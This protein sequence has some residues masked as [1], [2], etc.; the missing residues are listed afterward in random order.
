M[1]ASEIEREAKQAIK[2]RKAAANKALQTKKQNAIIEKKR[3]KSADVII[4]KIAASVNDY[5]L[6]SDPN[7]PLF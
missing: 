7:T 4:K 3:L 5:L 1:T 6:N 2:V